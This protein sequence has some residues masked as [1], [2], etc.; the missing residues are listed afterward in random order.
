MK[1]YIKREEIIEKIKDEM[2]EQYR[3]LIKLDDIVLEKRITYPNPKKYK[4][5]GDKEEMKKEYEEQE[6]TIKE[7]NKR[8]KEIIEKLEDLKKKLIMQIEEI[9]E[10]CSTIKERCNDEIGKQSTIIVGDK[11]DAFNEYYSKKKIESFEKML[12][13]LDKEQKEVEAFLARLKSKNFLSMLSNKDA[14]GLFNVA[15]EGVMNP[16]DTL[17]SGLKTVR[18]LPSILSLE[19]EYDYIKYYSELDDKYIKAIKEVEGYKVK[20]EK[21]GKLIFYEEVLKRQETDS[22]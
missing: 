22:S 7:I 15:K 2:L 18:G 21:G 5:A 9:L 16:L 13:K 19:T 11:K 6:R 17:K 8:K 20:T 12:G 14:R 4:G 1:Q 3:G 10:V